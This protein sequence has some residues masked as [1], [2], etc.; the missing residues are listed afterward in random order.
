VV[1]VREGSLKVKVKLCVSQVLLIERCLGTKVVHK[2][3]SGKCLV[4]I[5]AWCVMYIHDFWFAK[6]FAIYI[7]LEI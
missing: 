1:A 5:D 2:I 4:E 7:Y 6:W 3:V